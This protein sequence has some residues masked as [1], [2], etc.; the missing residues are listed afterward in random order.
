MNQTV[1]RKEFR[2]G[3][4]ESSG[5]WL[6]TA[7]AAVLSVLC[8]LVCMLKEGNVLAQSD[9]LQYAIKAVLFLTLTISMI[10]GATSFASEREENTLESLLLAPISKR[11][12][13]FA[14]FF[15]VLV[16]GTMLCLVAVP[17]L[18]AIGWGS[19]MVPDAMLI[20]FFCG[21]L[22][23]VGFVALS[24]VLSI[25][26]RSSRASILTSVLLMLVLTAPTFVEGLFNKTAIGSLFLKIDPVAN[27]FHMMKDML[28]NNASFFD[29]WHYI[30][31]L[32]LAVL[33]AVALLWIASGRIALKGEK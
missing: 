18:I 20:T 22:L 15:G 14:K 24:V 32:V 30:L 16:F 1:I 8:F 6:I 31:P 21:L 28:I 3:L 7:S 33:A 4:Y 19:G 25:T 10:L 5:L 12:L 29:E 2:E 9:V 26:M 17:Y 11:E 23:L 13:A 27:C